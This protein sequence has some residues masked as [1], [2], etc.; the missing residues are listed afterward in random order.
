MKTRTVYETRL[1]PHTVGGRTR[2]VPDEVAIE[3]PAPPRDWDR[4]VLT[5]VTAVA[6]LVLTAC[7]VWSTA[8][9][10]GLL[11]RVV[12]EP[13]AYGAAIVFDLAWIACMAVEWLA[14]YDPDR[15]RLP[16][17]A[18]HVALL[19]AMLAVGAHGWIAGYPEIGIVGAAVSGLAKGLWTVVLR[20]QTPPLDARTR[21]FLRQE[22]AE[23]GASLALIP[24]QRQVL[25]ARGLVAAE[26]AALPAGPDT[27]DADPDQSG[28]DTDRPDQSD[29]QPPGPPM[30]I[31]DAVRTAVDSG[32]TEPDRVLAYVRKRADA[33][34]R[35]DTVDR[36]IRLARMAG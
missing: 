26:Q 36:Y 7:V 31:K 8:S 5:G 4:T 20:H 32:L 6:V 22:L 13:A 17:A 35:P 10:G 30:T 3:L 11:S 12:I 19:V 21:E 34:A 28:Q 14:R 9:V 25:R 16:R 23:A 29:E 15:A 24:V 1:V 18:G 2:L 33:N 27:P